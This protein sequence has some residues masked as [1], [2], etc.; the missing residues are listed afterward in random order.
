MKKLLLIF[1]SLFIATSNLTN[2]MKVQEEEEI[3]LISEK[4]IESE[5]DSNL[6]N[7]LK[8]KFEDETFELNDNFKSEAQFAFGNLGKSDHF[9]TKKLK[10]SKKEILKEEKAEEIEIE[11][12]DKIKIQG[13][14]LDRGSDKA[15]LIGQGF[16]D[17]ADVLIPFFKLFPDYDILIINYRWSSSKFMLKNMTG[18][19]LDKLILKASGDVIASVKHIEDKKD[20][21]NITGVGLCY[22][23]L[24]YV[25][26]QAIQ[27]RYDQRLFDKLIIDSSYYSTKGVAESVTKDPILCCENKHG[28][29]PNCLQSIFSVLF[30]MPVTCLGSCCLGNKF[31]Y[32]SMSQY[33]PIINIPIM[34]IHGKKDLLVP[35]DPFFKKMY[36]AA[37]N[38]AFRCALITENP[39]V[40]HHFKSKEAY[41]YLAKLFIEAANGEDFRNFVKAFAK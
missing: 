14:F 11:T 26:A 24:V 22:S 7:R 17:C 28:G 29:T 9:D 8:F 31:E 37:C 33:L 21:K 10:N 23:G 18:E 36:K 35:Y 32:L 41:A 19:A 30:T 25:I 20:Y 40:L 1:L 39:H 38:T 27:S 6:T 13:Y 16:C 3:E 5:T 2:C 12:A 34:F 4:A 15:L